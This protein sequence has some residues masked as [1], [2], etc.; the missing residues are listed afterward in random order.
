ML[1]T[2]YQLH[3]IQQVS[4]DFQQ[5][6][7]LELF[8]HEHSFNQKAKRTS[9][10]ME[11]AL[12]T[13]SGSKKCPSI[14]QTDSA[15][16]RYPSPARVCGFRSHEMLRQQRWPQLWQ[17]LQCR[18]LRGMLDRRWSGNPNGWGWRMRDTIGCF[19]VA[20]IGKNKISHPF[21]YCVDMYTRCLVGHRSWFK[22]SIR[23][24]FSSFMGGIFFVDQLQEVIERATRFVRWRFVWP[25]EFGY[26]FML[27][28][29]IVLCTNHNYT[30]CMW[31]IHTFTLNLRFLS[32]S[33]LFSNLKSLLYD[34]M[35]KLC[36]FFRSCCVLFLFFN[37]E[38]Y[39][40]LCVFVCT[41]HFSPVELAL[42]LLGRERLSR[43]C[44]GEA[45]R[46]VGTH[47]G[48]MVG[49]HPWQPSTFLRK[50][51]EG[52]SAW[53]YFEIYCGNMDLFGNF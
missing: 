34:Y 23:E 3:I 5:V 32:I 4:N 21:R 14:R 51:S 7:P 40:S 33:K 38:S 16:P 53:N 12:Q 37:Y 2:S 30:W 1:K 43:C 25:W 49:T 29:D 47:I 17:V 31:G 39:G 45:R 13:I 50:I 15:T 9:N 10:L 36:A 35:L 46:Q 27:I 24:M 44:G 8:L 52:I 11:W 22:W 41:N 42:D 18:R 20:N 48:S 26:W 6:T 19:F 28:S